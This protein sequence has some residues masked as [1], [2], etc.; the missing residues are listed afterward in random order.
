MKLF[1]MSL[2]VFLRSK[3]PPWQSNLTALKLYQSLTE[4]VYYNRKM[5]Q[6]NKFFG[7]KRRNGSQNVWIEWQQ[8]YKNAV[9]L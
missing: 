5:K 3:Y 9:P 6:I 4:K 7:Q 8:D 1:I 2:H